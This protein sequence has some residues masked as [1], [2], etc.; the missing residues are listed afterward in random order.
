MPPVGLRRCHVAVR[1]ARWAVDV[2]GSKSARSSAPSG[3]GCMTGAYADEPSS[4]LACRSATGRVHADRMRK[5][6]LRRVRRSYASS[7]RCGATFKEAVKVSGDVAGKA[8]FDLSAG[9]SLG[10]AP[11]D[12]VAGGLL[13]LD[14]ALH[15]G[16]Q[17][18]V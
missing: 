4:T 9:L 14:P 1:R 6:M 11:G 8:A 16:V 10:G 5:I 3:F 2:V 13:V 18:I 7:S 12:V 17:C 15:H